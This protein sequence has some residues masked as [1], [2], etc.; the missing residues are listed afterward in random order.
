MSV[1]HKCEDCGEE[2]VVECAQQ[3][4]TLARFPESIDKISTHPNGKENVRLYAG[5]FLGVGYG[6]VSLGG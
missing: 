5:C 2:T 6:L 3:S 4:A 1:I